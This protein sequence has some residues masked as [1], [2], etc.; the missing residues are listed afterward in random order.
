MVSLEQEQHRIV[1]RASRNV[2]QIRPPKLVLQRDSWVMRLCCKVIV[3]H[4]V[5]AVCVS[6][7]FR[8]ES[9]FQTDSKPIPAM[10]SSG[11]TARER[12]LL[13]ASIRWE[14]IMETAGNAA[15][16]SR[17]TRARSSGTRHRVR[18][19]WKST[20]PSSAGQFWTD[21]AIQRCCRSSSTRCDQRACV[22]H[23]LSVPDFFQIVCHHV[24]RSFA[25]ER[26]LSAQRPARK[27][28]VR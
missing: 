16:A 5:L 21:A 22:T 6:G 25:R 18:I 24:P 1:L 13:G 11:S 10:T 17:G 15:H 3:E 28:A 20:N 9:V 12:I 26:R 23:Y 27:G 8:P 14:T 4:A 19:A 7:P 2:Y